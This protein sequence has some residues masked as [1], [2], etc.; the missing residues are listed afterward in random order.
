MLKQM[1]YVIK[2]EDTVTG[3]TGYGEPIEKSA[4]AAWVN[5]M[6]AKYPHIKH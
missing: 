3:E 6:N 2:W 4:A 1:L 5:T